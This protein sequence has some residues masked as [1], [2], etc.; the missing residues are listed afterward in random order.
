M[1]LR[2]RGVVVSLGIAALVTG[3]AVVLLA[4][5]PGSAAQPPPSSPLPSPRSQP[6]SAQ[7]L[8]PAT[9][10]AWGAK[11]VWVLGVRRVEQLDPY[12]L[13]PLAGEAFEG[14]CADS[15]MVFGLGGLWV[16]S[17]SC[18]NPGTLTRVTRTLTVDYQVTVP[19]QITG[20]AI[21]HG[22]VWLSDAS[23]G[24]QPLWTFNPATRRLA[25]VDLRIGGVLQTGRG[26]FRAASLVAAGGSLWATPVGGARPTII[27]REAG[28]LTHLDGTP[29]LTY[30]TSTSVAPVDAGDAV[31]MPFTN[32]VAPLD[33]I[34]GRQIGRTV[35]PPGLVLG[36]AGERNELFMATTE[37]IYRTSR[38]NPT[39]VRLTRLAFDPRGITVGFGYVWA[40]GG[41]KLVRIDNPDPQTETP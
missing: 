14:I 30:G 4:R 25:A 11:A 19:G 7:L 27:L 36:L 10:V 12:T 17:G 8:E 21:W 26:A 37:G 3:L 24:V 20:V 13:Q 18:G 22:R 31:W 40:I 1:M 33:P 41:S 32:A 2:G 38:S 6:H 35:T 39:P 29:I 34:E 23:D 15:R 9:A 16:T 5:T 28:G